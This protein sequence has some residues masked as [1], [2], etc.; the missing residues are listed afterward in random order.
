MVGWTDRQIDGWMERGMDGG[1]VG[2][3]GGW[4]RGGGREG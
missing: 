2:E 3:K 1:G 4:G